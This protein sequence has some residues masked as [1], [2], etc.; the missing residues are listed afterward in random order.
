MAQETI[1][2]PKKT[3][4]PP[5]LKVYGDIQSLTKTV[6]STSKST[7]APGTPPNKTQ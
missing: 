6:G 7:D 1:G 2:S 5:G 4:N 3:Y